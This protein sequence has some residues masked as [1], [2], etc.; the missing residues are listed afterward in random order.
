MSLFY[1]C[2]YKQYKYKHF[3]FI[4]EKKFADEIKKHIKIKNY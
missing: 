2:G 1:K 3:E 4:I